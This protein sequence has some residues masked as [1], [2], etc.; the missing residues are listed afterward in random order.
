MV[1]TSIDSLEQGASPRP[2][3][4]DFHALLG[5][6]E[7]IKVAGTTQNVAFS[8]IFAQS[9]DSRHPYTTLNVPEC[10]PTTFPV[11]PENFLVP[12]NPILV[13]GRHHRRSE[14]KLLP[15]Q[16]FLA[17]PTTMPNP[18][19]KVVAHTVLDQIPWMAPLS[20]FLEQGAS[21]GLKNPDF[22][23]LLGVW[24]SIKA[25]RFRMGVN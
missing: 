1:G 18:T 14:S 13:H 10:C 24:E 7:S 3:N 25:Q 2:K 9:E 6:W 4:P 12:F 20:I 22:H 19:K 17:L 15:N 8:S 11:V 23:A 5:V 21:P 16:T